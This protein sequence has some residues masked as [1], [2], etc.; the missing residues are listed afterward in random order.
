MTAAPTTPPLQ[1][2]RQVDVAYAGNRAVGQHRL[3]V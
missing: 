3:Q 1:G 2:V